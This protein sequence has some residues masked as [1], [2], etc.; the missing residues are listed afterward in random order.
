[1]NI[2]YK[3]RV[4]L[5]SLSGLEIAVIGLVFLAPKVA[6]SWPS[7][8]RFGKKFWGLMIFQAWSLYNFEK[9]CVP[10]AIQSLTYR[11]LNLAVYC[12]FRAPDT[13]T[14]LSPLPPL[15]FSVHWGGRRPPGRAGHSIQGSVQQSGVCCI[16][17]S[18]CKRI[19]A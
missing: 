9:H 7:V 8:D 6:F 17:R 13:F 4:L 10:W 16:K 11:E 1:M 15:R 18:V 3:P 5:E 2:R 19:T 12:R 14:A